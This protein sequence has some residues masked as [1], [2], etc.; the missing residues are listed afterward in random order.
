MRYIILK[1]FTRSVLSITYWIS[2]L[3]HFLLLL[4]IGTHIFHGLTDSI[5][6]KPPVQL[7]NSFLDFRILPKPILI[8]HGQK[9]GTVQFCVLVNPGAYCD[10]RKWIVRKDNIRWRV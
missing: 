4:F 9:L 2:N 6:Q 3:F 10:L 7:I 1:T 8:R 5:W